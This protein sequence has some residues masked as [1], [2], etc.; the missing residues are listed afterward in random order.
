MKKGPSC[1]QSL[2][3]LKSATQFPAW[4]EREQ[5]SSLVSLPFLMEFS[6]VELFLVQHYINFAFHFRSKKGT[7]WGLFNAAAYATV[8]QADASESCFFTNENETAVG[9]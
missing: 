7:L 3:A 5:R 9:C 4:A 2:P 1:T 6:V 8:P